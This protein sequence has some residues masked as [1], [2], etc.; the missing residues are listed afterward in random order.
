MLPIHKLEGDY[1]PPDG[2]R[3]TTDVMLAPAWE[4]V[5]DAIRRLDRDT[6]RV[7]CIHLNALAGDQ[8]HYCMVMGGAAEW[9]HSL[10]TNS[11]EYALRVKLPGQ[12]SP[13][14]YLDQSRSASEMVEVWTDPD[15]T[16]LPECTVC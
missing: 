5:E 6:Y 14:G 8:A 15:A 9:A 11:A 10:F 16:W 13:L 4:D 3:R 1:Y 12:R 2:S 7:V